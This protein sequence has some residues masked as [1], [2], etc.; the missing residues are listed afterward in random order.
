MRQE[1]IID[2]LNLLEDDILEETDALRRHGR[3][4][5]V[6]WRRVGAG[7][8][9]CLVLACSWWIFYQNRNMDGEGGTFISGYPSD[10]GSAELS[11]GNGENSPIKDETEGQLPSSEFP[12]GTDSTEI[13][14]NNGESTPAMEEVDGLPLV[15]TMD[16]SAYGAGFGGEMAYDV[17]ELISGNPWSESDYFPALPVYRNPIN[18]DAHNNFKVTGMDI[19]KMWEVLQ[20]TIDRLGLD[21][22]GLEMT[23]PSISLDSSEPIAIEEAEVSA[24]GDGI[25]L[26]VDASLTV[27]IIFDPPVTLPDSYNNYYNASYEEEAALGEYLQ[28]A[29]SNLIG[30]N[31]PIFV[32]AGGGYDIY[33]NQS[34]MKFYYN[35]EGDL[36]E[37][38]LN[39]NFHRIAFYGNSYGNQLDR[40]RIFQRDRSQKL[41]DYPIITVEK[42]RELLLEGKYVTS[43]PYEV[44]GEEYVASVELLYSTGEMDEY[45]MPYYRFYVELPEER[46]TNQEAQ[47]RGLLTYGI[48]YVPAVEE[49]YLDG[50]SLWH[51]NF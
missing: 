32:V 8:A 40:I 44:P 30:W 1:Q 50:K 34:Y 36:T 51:F 23:G 39:Y 25:E 47:K 2:A 45:F 20:D 11:D 17:S 19:E 4:A 22:A 15:S 48:Y 49:K 31:E 41:G 12:S 24:K 26:T 6:R 18:I 28:D 3:T 5:A 35:G 27:E 37:K 16:F 7:M 13:A 46:D 38:F 29:F 10:A 9:A 43:V 21:N 42:A 14:D 33:G